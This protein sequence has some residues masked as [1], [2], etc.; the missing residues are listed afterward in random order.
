MLSRQAR[1]TAEQQASQQGA[2]QKTAK[3]THGARWGLGSVEGSEFTR[4][5]PRGPVVAPRALAL[6]APPARRG[7]RPR[8]HPAGG[9]GG[10]RFFCNATF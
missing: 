1:A 8:L 4:R 2:E 6:A 3:G 5:P 10:R 9:R 7:P